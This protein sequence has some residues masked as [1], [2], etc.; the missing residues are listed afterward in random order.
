MTPAA[1][2]QSLKLSQAMCEALVEIAAHGDVRWATLAPR[3][4]TI[5]ALVRKGMLVRIDNKW[6]PSELGRSALHIWN[7]P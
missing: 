5:R 6:I 2:A 7:Q 1:K 3:P 4:A